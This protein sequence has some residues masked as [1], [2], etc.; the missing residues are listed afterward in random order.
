APSA[1][2]VAHT[3]PGDAPPPTGPRLA[4]RAEHPNLPDDLT[5]E[6]LLEPPQHRRGLELELRR[7]RRAR[8]AEHEHAVLEGLDG[9][10]VGDVRAHELGPAGHQATDGELWTPATLAGQAFE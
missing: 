9:A 8:R 3:P 1:V 5:A 6:L 7:P 2:G 4:A 10:V